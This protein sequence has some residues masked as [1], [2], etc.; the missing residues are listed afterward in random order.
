[1]I[2]VENLKTSIGSVEILHDISLDV[3]AGK[4]VCVIGANGAGK[5]TLLR[6]ISNVL[7]AKAGEIV[8]DGQSVRGVAPHTLARRGLV[9]VPQ[10]RQIIPNLSVLDNLTIGASRIAGLGEAEIAESLEREFN[11]FPVLRERQTIPGG[12]LSGGEQQMLALSRA[13]MM[14]PK[15]LMLDEPSLGLAPQI[16]KSILQSLRSLA[17]D[18]LAVLLIEQLAFLALDIA[19]DAHVLQRG[20]LVMSG[21]AAELRHDR[22][23][24]ESYLS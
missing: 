16:V 7:P 11:R 21:P 15:V 14:R 10:G 20:R 18:G 13:L 9:Q 5:T 2:K 3:P 12:S 22:S 24:I 4:L 8:F 17:N 23:V 19:D 6:S 1:M